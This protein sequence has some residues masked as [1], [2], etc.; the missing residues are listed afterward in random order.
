MAVFTDIYS[1]ENVN[2]V[3]VSIVNGCVKKLVL[4]FAPFIC[5]SLCFVIVVVCT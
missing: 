5:L 1:D 2:L 4:Y 3:D